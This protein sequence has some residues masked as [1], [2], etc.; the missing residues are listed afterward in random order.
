MKLILEG[1]DLIIKKIEDDN[2]TVIASGLLLKKYKI[3]K[4]ILNLKSAYSCL[5][6]LKIVKI[7]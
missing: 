1:E 3:V 7:N 2:L 4:V 6:S 5:R